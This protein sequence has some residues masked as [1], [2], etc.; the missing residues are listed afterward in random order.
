MGTLRNDSIKQEISETLTVLKSYFQH[1]HL[2]VTSSRSAKHGAFLRMGGRGISSLR[3]S[4][5]GCS[6][7]SFR[8]FRVPSIPWHKDHT[9]RTPRDAEAGLL[10]REKKEATC[11]VAKNSDAWKRR[12]PSGP[13]ALLISRATILASSFQPVVWPMRNFVWSYDFCL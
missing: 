6:T 5:L 4:H 13:Q 12:L 10:W 8:F 9:G 7:E 11:E 1:V 3:S 2:F